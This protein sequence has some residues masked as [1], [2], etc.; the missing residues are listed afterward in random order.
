MVLVE[1]SMGSRVKSLQQALRDKGF[2]PGEIDGDFG[3]ATEAAVIAF[4]TSEG[5]LAD[6]KVGS[7]TLAALE[8]EIEPEDARADVTSSFTVSV[9]SKMSPSSPI[10]NIKT[11]LPNILSE[12]KAV[13]LDDRD[14]VLIAIATIRAETE[15]FIPI[16]EFESRFNT[17]PNGSPFSLYDNRKDLGN[18]GSPDGV[19]FKGRG[20]VQ[21][22]GRD[23][24]TR[25]GQQIGVDLITSPEKANDPVIAAKIL[26]R[27]LKNSEL[28]VR[29]ALLNSDL[30]AARRCVNGG[31]HGFERFRMAFT[32]GENLIA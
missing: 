24:Y 19:N 5:L 1:G 7:K 17:P 4:Q 27:F 18:K 3:P 28:C 32:I 22:T 10:K 25:I 29:S 9:V 6:G 21:L 16:D 20:F 15:G 13:G 2:N 30:K 23:N 12:L 8:L 11:Y 26:A 31:I 14:M